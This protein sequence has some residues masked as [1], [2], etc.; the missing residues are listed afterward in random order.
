MANRSWFFATDGQQHGPYSEDQF[1][2]LIGKG[3]IGPDT[4]V[5]S[6][7]MAAWQL[8]GDIPGLLSSGTRPPAFPG[9]GVPMA[10]GIGSGMLSLE[11]GTW[12]LLGRSLIMFI[13]NLLVIPAPWAV[14][15]FYRWLVPHL[16][17]PQRPSLGFTGQPGD[18]WY[19]FV[20]LALCS[21]AGFSG[22]DYLEYILLPV[23]GFLSWM[24]VRWFVANISCNGQRLPLT[25]T[26]QP[27][28]Y[29][30][31]YLLGIVSIVTIIGWAWVMT[32][33]MRWVCR[34]IAGTRREVTF[35]ASGWQV[36]WR[37]ILFALGVV[38]IIPIPWALS[39]YLRWTVSQFELVERTA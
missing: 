20:L 22:V 4:Y 33:L 8:A 15:G 23:Q 1:R 30:G 26:G 16:R 18:I 2:D 28:V 36:L 34:N 32:A 38:L 27:W 6:E 24:T 31:W 37:T 10:Q 25:F 5:W 13:G 35:I 29:V 9:S 3:G 19:V 11:A 12:A 39:W 14:T 7:G 21:Y 17:V